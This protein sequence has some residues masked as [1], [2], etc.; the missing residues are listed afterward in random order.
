MPKADVCETKELDKVP[1]VMFSEKD[2]DADSYA[3]S[4]RQAKNRLEMK[5]TLLFMCKF[6]GLIWKSRK[7]AR[8]RHEKT[9]NASGGPQQYIIK[10]GRPAKGTSLRQ[11][12][13]DDKKM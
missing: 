8:D 13:S 2:I 3:K 10:T 9:C 4:F 6:C 7:H 5:K 11:L 12:M 1:E